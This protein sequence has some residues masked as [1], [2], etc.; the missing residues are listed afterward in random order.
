[1]LKSVMLERQLPD[2][3]WP[4]LLPYAVEVWNNTPK[5]DGRPA[6][7]QLRSP[8]SGIEVPEFVPGERVWFQPGG[9][10]RPN[11]PVPKEARKTLL[12]RV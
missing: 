7:V 4:L 12:K 11:W 9:V 1:M 6:P 3:A 2:T 5:S 10:N 8:L